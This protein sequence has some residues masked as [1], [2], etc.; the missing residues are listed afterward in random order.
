MRVKVIL[1]MLLALFASQTAFAQ[2]DI[3]KCATVTVSRAT[4]ADIPALIADAECFNSAVKSA[5]NSETLRLK[6]ARELAQQINPDPAPTPTPEPPPP[7]Q[8]KVL[9]LGDSITVHE[10]GYAWIWARAHPD[11]AFANRAWGG[12]S[13]TDLAANVATIIPAEKPT[14][15]T[16][17]MGANDLAVTTP[18][19]WLARMKALVADIRTLQPGVKIG[20]AGVLPINPNLQNRALHNPRRAVV[21]AA[22]SSADWIDFY[23]PIGDQ[24]TDA[25]ASNPALSNDGLH[26][27]GTSGQAYPRMASAYTNALA[28]I[29]GGHGGHGPPAPGEFVPLTIDDVQYIPAEVDAAKWIGPAAIPRSMAPDDVGAMRF[30]CNTSHLAYD[31]PIVFPGEAGAAHL[32]M[33]FGNTEADANST[34]ESLRL[35]GDSSCQIGPF[36]RSSYWIP[37]LLQ[38]K[39]GVPGWPAPS[40]DIFDYDVVQPDNLSLY[41]KRWP[42]SAAECTRA[43]HLGCVPIHRAWQL[44]FGTNY[45]QLSNQSPHV[46]F[47]CNVAGRSWDNLPDAVE[48]CRGHPK[49]HARIVAPNCWNGRDLTAVDHQSHFAYMARDIN[50]GRLHCPDTHRYI[51]PELTLGV[52]WSLS[53]LARPATL[54]F[55]SD[56]QLGRK[57][58]TTFHADYL[59]A[60]DE[61]IQQIWEDHCIN[62]LLDCSG[63]NLGNGTIGKQPIPFSFEQRPLLLPVPARP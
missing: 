54:I 28:G 1:A 20:V 24:F 13:I 33:F 2:Q 21:N 46:R 51:V 8:A 11:I 14:I 10:S 60:W 34:Y 52:T 30:I 36:N 61:A 59:P 49:L 3:T 41:Y 29:L 55:S 27:M 47:D 57:P 58:G 50:T 5:A 38:A 17:L 37:A 53:E 23:I 26:W 42:A 56:L 22:L 35:S 7:L 4:P 45:T 25:D 31:D 63:G 15:V 32:H 16:I 43:P 40:P 9:A 19:V 44:I 18:E 48:N 62:G 12:W 6:K 39:E